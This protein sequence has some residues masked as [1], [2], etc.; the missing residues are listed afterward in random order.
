MWKLKI[1]EGEGSYLYSTNKFVGRQVWVFEADAGTAQEREEVEK[2]RER[3]RIN[4]TTNGVHACGDLLM[5]M[6]VIIMIIII[7][8]GH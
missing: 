2:V 6:Q 5:R 3:F 8:K 1:A 7:I 4:C